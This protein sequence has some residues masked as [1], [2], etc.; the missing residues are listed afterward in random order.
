MIGYLI[1]FHEPRDL[2]LF[3]FCRAKLDTVGNDR[4]GITLFYLLDGKEKCFWLVWLFE[5]L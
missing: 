1:Y 5:A 4:A 3:D 2:T